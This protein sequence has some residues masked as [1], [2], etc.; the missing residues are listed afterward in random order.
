M[1]DG[2]PGTARWLLAAALALGGCTAFDT[3][4]TY[5]RHRLSEITLP[6]DGGGDSMSS[7]IFYFDVTV[8]AE[9]PENSADAEAE[10]M[11]WLAEWLEQRNMCPKGHEVLKKRKFD[12][13]EDNPA[14]RDLRYEARCTGG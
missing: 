4:D 2:G 9:F 5:N 10:R 14:R 3:P 13:M 8:T 7:D 1:R 11:Q 12:Y 6:R